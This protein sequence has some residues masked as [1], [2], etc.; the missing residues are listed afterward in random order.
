MAK[1]IGSRFFG[2]L[3]DCT[4]LLRGCSISD[5][6]REGYFRYVVIRKSLLVVLMLIKLSSPD[7]TIY[8]KDTYPIPLI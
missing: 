4:E 7:A 6:G 5:A 2:S 3:R 1:W 8:L